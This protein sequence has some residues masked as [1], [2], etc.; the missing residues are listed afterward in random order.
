MKYRLWHGL[1]PACLYIVYSAGR[2]PALD[3]VHLGGLYCSGRTPYWNRYAS[4][5][6]NRSRFRF[7]AAR[8]FCEQQWTQTKI[9]LF[10]HMFKS[11]Q[12]KEGARR[13][14]VPDI[15]TNPKTMINCS[16]CIGSKFATG[17][18]GIAVSM[19]RCSPALYFASHHFKPD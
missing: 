14:G 1:A 4:L 6:G 2:S 8:S 15:C 10:M 18:K 19:T 13:V 17:S 16:L 11:T 7:F 5:N 9:I 3:E 12:R